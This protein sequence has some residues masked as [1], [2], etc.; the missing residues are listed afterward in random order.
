MEI[1]TA[2]VTGATGYVGSLLVGR[3]ADSG[4]AVKVLVR[5][6]GKARRMP[7]AHMIRDT[8]QPAS[9]DVAIVVGNA[10]EQRDVERA[11]EGVDVAWYLLHSMGNERDFAD[12]ECEMAEVFARAVKHAGTE[13][14]V[15]LGALAPMGEK[16]LHLESRRE[17]GRILERSGAT[18]VG[19]SA[20][21]V[22]GDRSSSFA[23]LRHLAERLPM[24]VAPRWMHNRITPISEKDLLYLLDIAGTA[25]IPESRLFDIGSAEEVSYVE[26]LTRYVTHFRLG[27]KRVLTA[28]IGNA[29]LAAW[30]ISVLTPVDR[31]LAEPLVESMLHDTIVAEWDFSRV[32]GEPPGGLDD[33][34]EAFAATAPTIRPHRWRKIFAGVSGSVAATAVVASALM[35]VNSSW[36]RN[37]PKTSLTPPRWVFPV[38]WTLLYTDIALVGSLTLADI[39]EADP[40]DMSTASATA[41]LT[42]K[43]K[44]FIAA[45]GANLA[46]NAAWPLVF[47]RLRHLPAA[48]VEG[49][50]LAASSID[51]VRRVWKVNASRGAGL[52]PY[53]LWTAY[54]ATLTARV[55]YKARR[56]RRS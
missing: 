12:E 29:R 25:D 49:A 46:L 26:M 17:V 13:R 55:A 14:I 3:L 10:L 34:D 40:S 8:P 28:P 35:R 4:W 5:D 54:A 53:A 56:N 47:F 50:M 22:V 30:A 11:L 24:I 1:K 16:S 37:L 41:Q 51:L 48:T 43:E 19:L 31:H 21:L 9:G 36:Y 2:L 38:V 20:G 7:W 6:A 27:R 15:F 44:G 33:L 32:V 39:G 52:T 18:T 45:L 42:P 23:M